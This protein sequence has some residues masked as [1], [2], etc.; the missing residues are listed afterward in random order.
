MQRF[1]LQ[2]STETRFFPHRG[3]NFFTAPRSGLGKQTNA[4]L[5]SV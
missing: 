4:F 3:I 1:D 5:I 2:N